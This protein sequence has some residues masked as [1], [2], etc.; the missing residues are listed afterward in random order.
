M[1]VQQFL[2]KSMELDQQE[3]HLP[4][5]SEGAAAGTAGSSKAAATIVIGSASSELRRNH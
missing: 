2:K 3:S 4:E 1:D 5:E